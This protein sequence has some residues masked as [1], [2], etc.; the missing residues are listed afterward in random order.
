MAVILSAYEVSTDTNGFAPCSWPATGHREA[1]QIAQRL[2]VELQS[3]RA[4]PNAFWVSTVDHRKNP[5]PGL[6]RGTRFL[7][8]FFRGQRY[9]PT[10]T[11]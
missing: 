7:S 11:I 1:E 9:A 3:H 5:P 8:K 2:S 10:D 6:F 4:Y